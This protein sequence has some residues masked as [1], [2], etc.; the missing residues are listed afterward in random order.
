MARRQR[1]PSVIS[2]CAAE[3]QNRHQHSR[4]IEFSA[5]AVEDR[6]YAG[7]LI[8]FRNLPD[9]LLVLPYSL[10]KHVKF[11]VNPDHLW[12]SDSDWLRIGEMV[13]ERRK[14]KVDAAQNRRPTGRVK[15]ESA[16]T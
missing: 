15:T 6:P 11:N 9:H 2:P 1:K 8:E 14:A 7:G 3:A 10:D 16:G 5:G 13:D 12:L 4:I